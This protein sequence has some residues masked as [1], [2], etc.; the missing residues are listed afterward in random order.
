MR[1]VLTLALLAIVL[2]LSWNA[3]FYASSMVDAFMALALGSALITLLVVQPSWINL[4][5]VFLSS[6][7]LAALDYRV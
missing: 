1:T 5:S 7:V 3:D 4:A 2:V 6:I